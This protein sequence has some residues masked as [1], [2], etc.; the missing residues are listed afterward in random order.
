MTSTT[1]MDG[2]LLL[3]SGRRKA[4]QRVLSSGDLLRKA[5]G[6]QRHE[7]RTQRDL[8]LFGDVGQAEQAIAWGQWCVIR[9]MHA[10]AVPCLRLKL[11]RRLEEIDEQT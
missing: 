7:L 8:G 1:G 3:A 4:G 11:E 10:S 2:C 5:H 9:F 6:I